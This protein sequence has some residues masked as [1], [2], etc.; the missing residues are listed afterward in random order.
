MGKKLIPAG[1]AYLADNITSKQNIL[2]VSKKQSARWAEHL[3]LPGRA[4]TVFFAGCGY[5]FPD[6][7]EK[8]TSLLRQM[9]G[10]AVGAELPMRLASLP[11]KLGLDLAGVYGSVTARGDGARAEP[12]EAAVKVLQSLEVP[13]GYLA[14]E[15]PCC[16]GGGGF[17]VVFPELSQIL[18]S[19]RVSELLESGAGTI[20]TS[21][22]GCIMQLRAGLKGLKAKG[23]EVL[24]LS[25]VV[26]TA[27]GV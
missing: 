4:E 27:M 17:E 2:G 7:L 22:P 21:C 26:A 10:S 14:G 3:K 18:A 16:G 23:V 15:E 11:K 13:F 9:D 1:L 12:L 25:Q 20:V 8:L 5:Q 24:D 19:N 6:R